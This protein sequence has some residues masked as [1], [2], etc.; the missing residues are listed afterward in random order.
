MHRNQTHPVS[1]NDAPGVAGGIPSETNLEHGFTYSHNI[2]RWTRCCNR[3]EGE[4]LIQN[5]GI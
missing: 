5:F 3:N 4:G 1:S 2:K